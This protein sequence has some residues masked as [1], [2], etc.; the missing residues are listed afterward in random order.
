[1]GVAGRAMYGRDQLTVAAISGGSREAFI[2]LFD[3]TSGAIHAELASRLPDLDQAVPVFA[4][5]YVEVWWLAGCHSGP[6]VDAVEWIRRILHRRIADVDRSARQRP[7]RSPA[8]SDPA[9]DTWPSCAERELAALLGRPV[10]RS[11]LH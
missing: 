9:P 1:M 2:S 5:T 10:R 11:G 3:R 6:D 8:A 7:R 4:A